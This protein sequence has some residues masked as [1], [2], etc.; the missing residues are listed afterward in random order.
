M[1]E[2]T[3]FSL[4]IPTF[5]RPEPL[6]SCLRGVSE[7][8]FPAEHFE[9]VV[10][11]DGSPVPVEQV[12]AP[13]HDRLRLVVVTGPNA[14]PAAARNRGAARAA[15]QY[16]VFIDDDCVPDPEL[17]A[18]LERRFAA[19]PDALIG[20]GIVNAL[21]ENP[22]STATQQIIEYVYQYSERMQGK[23]RLFTTSI[24]AVSTEGFRRLGGFSEDLTTGE[25]YDFCHRWQ[26]AGGSAVYAREAA[27]HHAHHLTLRSFWRQHFRYGRGLLLCRLRMAQRTGHRLRGE[28]VIFYLELLRFPLAQGDGARGWLHAALVAASQVATAAGAAWQAVALGVRRGRSGAASPEFRTTT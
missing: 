3:L 12:V 8:R 9:V 5:A 18:A 14:G 25:D 17:L 20:G 26:H 15:G 1:P 16:L 13:F 10:S 19:T 24:L 27:V 11:D 4:V 28:R 23:T 21:P 2:T 22:F 7:I 6:K